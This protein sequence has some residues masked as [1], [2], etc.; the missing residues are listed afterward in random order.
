MTRLT[1]FLPWIYLDVLTYL[2]RSQNT[3]IDGLPANVVPEECF[4][5]L[6]VRAPDG[7]DEGRGD[8]R[9]TGEGTWMRK[10]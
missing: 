8:V 3:L 2:A 9:L 5:E 4:E 1:S 6:A 10:T 7:E